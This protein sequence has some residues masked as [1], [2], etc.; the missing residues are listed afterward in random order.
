MSFSLPDFFAFKPLLLQEL[1]SRHLSLRERSD[2]VAAGR[3]DV[4]QCEPFHSMKADKAPLPRL[5]P[6]PLPRER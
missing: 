5:K 6:R 1:R 4:D 3:G 2:A